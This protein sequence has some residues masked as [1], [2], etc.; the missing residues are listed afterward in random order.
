MYR[1]SDG[2][3]VVQTVDFFSPIVDDPYLFGQIAA[4]NAISDVYAMNARPL[5][6]LNIVGFPS[7]TLPLQ[8]LT[9][10]LRG[11]SDKA[12]EAGIPV[13]GG[14]TVD[15]SEPKY[16]MVVT[17]LVEPGRVTRNKGARPGDQLVL[18]KPLGT[19]IVANAAKKGACSPAVLEAAIA[20]MTTLNKGGAAAMGEVGAEACTDVTGYGLVGHLRGMLRASGAAARLFG[21]KLPEIPGARALAAAGN[22]PGGSKRNRA[23]YGDSLVEKGADELDVAL[24]TDAQTSG[25]L[26]IAVAPEKLEPLL[27]ALAK[28]KT[29]AAA[30]VGEVIDGPAGTIELLP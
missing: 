10:I 24:A 8:I 3:A 15:D 2:S 21:S 26:L 20:S 17:G 9:D 25:G 30:H 18:T 4:A 12:R 28:E 23:Y 16:G 7:K 14:H 27:A 6:A 5:F 29:P 11:G 19:G 1:L 22:V 13:L